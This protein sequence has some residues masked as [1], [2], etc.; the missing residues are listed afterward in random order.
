[1]HDAVRHY[2]AH[3]IALPNVVLDEFCQRLIPRTLKAKTYW[4]REG[5]VCRAVAFVNRG[6]LRYFYNTDGIERTGQFFFE[7]TWYTDYHSFL[8]EKPAEQSV[9]AL[10]RSELLLLPKAVLY[11]YYDRYPQFERFGGLPR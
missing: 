11:E 8:T 1:M 6:C 3:Y 2:L 4:L 7:N 9:Q 10:E 5:E